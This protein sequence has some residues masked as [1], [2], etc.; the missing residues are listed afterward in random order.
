MKKTLTN[1]CLIPRSAS[2][3]LRAPTLSARTCASVSKDTSAGSA[4]WMMRA[5]QNSATA[6]TMETVAPVSATMTL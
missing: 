6:V 1:A 5:M 3:E 2:T 4:H